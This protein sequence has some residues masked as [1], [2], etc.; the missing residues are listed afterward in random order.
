M[1]PVPYYWVFRLFP[2]PIFIFQLATENPNFESFTQIPTRNLYSSFQDK[3]IPTVI[4]FF[5]MTYSLCHNFITAKE[6]LNLQR[7]SV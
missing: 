4:H 1:L 2:M 7:W 6:N 5:H 3:E